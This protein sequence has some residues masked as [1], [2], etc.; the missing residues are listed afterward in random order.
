MPFNI[1]DVFQS[2]WSTTINSDLHFA[3]DVT[4]LNEYL[5]RIFDSLD[6]LISD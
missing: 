3:I 5:T 1:L 4:F 6:R 2:L